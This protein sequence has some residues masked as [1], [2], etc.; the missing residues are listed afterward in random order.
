MS[1]DRVAWELA[2]LTALS[3]IAG[4]AKA[5]S[6]LLKQ[7]EQAPLTKPA[8]PLVTVRAQ[9]EA[10]D[11]RVQAFVSSSIREPFEGSLARWNGPICPVVVGLSQGEDQLV[12]AGLAEIAMA[13]GAQ[14]ADQPCQ[15]NFAVIMVAEPAAVLKAWYKRDWH[16]FGDAT[17]SRINEWVKTPRAARVWYNIKNES[18]SGVPYAIVPT[19]LLGP[20]APGMSI[21]FDNSAEASH[22]VFNSVRAFSSVIVVIDSDRAKGISLDKLADYA[23]MVGLVEIQLDADFGEA[24]TIL[25]LFSASEWAN[26]TGLSHWDSAVLKALY[27]TSQATKLQRSEIAQRM[28]RELTP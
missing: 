27:T 8:L 19:G 26:P 17:E 11:R 24:P 9:R 21:P 16:L 22:I 2:V 28:L 7:A 3:L 14:V 4:G 6:P 12:R 18:A 1:A 23:A 5:D 10:L 15:A 20:L 13:A 25:R